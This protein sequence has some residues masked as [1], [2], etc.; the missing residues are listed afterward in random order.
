MTKKLAWGI[1]SKN[2]E[3]LEALKWLL[4]ASIDLVV[5]EGIAGSGNDHNHGYLFHTA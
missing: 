2:P 5:L 4:D 3:Q 1:K